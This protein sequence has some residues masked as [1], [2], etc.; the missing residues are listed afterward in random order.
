[1]TAL[2]LGK[3]RTGARRHRTLRVGRNH[4]VLGG[5]EIPTT[6]VGRKEDVTPR[7]SRGTRC[8]WCRTDGPLRWDEHI[9][10]SS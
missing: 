9:L 8:E 3:R 4:P 10:T 5:H 2:D 6:L 7:W 1:V